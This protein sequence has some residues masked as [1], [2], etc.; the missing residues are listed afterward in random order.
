MRLTR[1]SV[2][3]LALAALS[4]G[5]RAFAGGRPS[6][7]AEIDRLVGDVCGRQVVMLGED[8]GHG[9]GATIAAKAAVVEKLVDSCGFSVVVFESQVYDFLDLQERFDRKVAT[10]RDV[11][12][13]IGGLWSTTAEMQPLIDFLYRRA[14]KGDIRLLGLDPQ[15]GGATQ[16]YAMRSL[17]ADLAAPLAGARKSECEAAIHRVANWEYDDG[18]AYDERERER[19]RACANDIAAAQADGTVA[20]MAHSLGAFL[21]MARGGTAVRDRAMHENLAWQLSRLPSASKAVV[22][23]AT[24][25]ALKA[26]FK[27]GYEPLGAYVHRAHGAAAASIGFTAS[28]G[29][30]GRQGRPAEILALAPAGSLEADVAARHGAAWHYADA[31]ELKAL[32][33]VRT[34]VLAHGRFDEAEWANLL[35]GIVVL[36]AEH[37]PHYLGKPG[38]T[39]GP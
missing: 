20:F 5:G 35:D 25:H 31:G 15:L 13:A 29:S 32:G 34:R 33:K 23:C 4:A 12:D 19:L 30:E 1:I 2:F 36:P 38:A 11:A 14:A 6:S 18:H 22:W 3:L 21:D 9:A 17:A 10:R 7:N 28:A 27:G 37:P 16:R 24:V 8:A 26:P 39:A